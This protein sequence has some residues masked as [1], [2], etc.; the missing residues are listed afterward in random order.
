MSIE[1]IIPLT[2]SAASL[3]ATFYFNHKSASD[4][5]V[6]MLET[7]VK[8]CETDRLHLRERVADL[9]RSQNLLNAHFAEISMKLKR[10]E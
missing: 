7:Q 5:R 9:E 2:I 3:S 6:T 4:R 1:A 8:D 10:N